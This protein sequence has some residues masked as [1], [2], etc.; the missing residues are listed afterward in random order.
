[1]VL[2]D[3]SAEVELFDNYAEGGL[4]AEMELLNIDHNNQ[5]LLEDCEVGALDSSVEVELCGNFAVVELCDN[6]AVVPLDKCT[7]EE[8]LAWALNLDH[9][10]QPLLE[11]YE[12]GVLEPQDKSAGEELLA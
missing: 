12:V 10:Y 8:L 5:P 11:D 7:E 6:F 4:L 9:N 3:N 2:L 1:M